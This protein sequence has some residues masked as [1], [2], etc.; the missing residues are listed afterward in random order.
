LKNPEEAKRWGENGRK[1]VLKEF[2]WDI[3]AK[4]TLRIYEELT[5]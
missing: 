1:R 3:A 2:T 5:K 4:K